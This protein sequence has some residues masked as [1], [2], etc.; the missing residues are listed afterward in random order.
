M[1][2]GIASRNQLD[3][4]AP[5]ATPANRL[6][7]SGLP[8]TDVLDAAITPRSKLT[9][10]GTTPRPVVRGPGPTKKV[11]GEK[12]VCS[13]EE[14]QMAEKIFAKYDV[15]G[16]GEV[17]IKAFTEMCSDVD[18]P[19]DPV[20]ARE[21]L[22]E[23]KNKR[24]LF[25]ADFKDIYARIL[26]AQTPAVRSSALGRPIGL[27]ALLA[28]E[29]HSRE[30][31]KRFAPEGL[32]AVEMLPHVLRTLGFTDIHGDGFDRYVGE[33]MILEKKSDK[34]MI[35]FHD[36][37]SCTNLLVDFIEKSLSK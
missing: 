29:S 28:T 12:P 35:N 18:L 32:L 24:G 9:P 2:P 27:P 13:P 30:A 16:I 3:P 4:A 19:V 8:L 20:M 11:A 26:A 21:W 33:W 17:D 1:V 36:F 6:L 7:L 37:V 23:V 5:F 25:L 34:A 15:A 10:R 22:A 14:S 31:F